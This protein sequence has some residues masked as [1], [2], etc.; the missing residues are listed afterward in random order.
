M[1]SP[2]QLFKEEIF[3]A[4]RH[5]DYKEAILDKVIEQYET[6]GPSYV[7]CKVSNEARIFRNWAR[8]VK[9]ERH[10]AIALIRLIP[11]E[12]RGVL[13]G[14]F[15]VRHKTHELIMLHFMKRFPTYSILIFFGNEACVGRDGEIFRETVERPN[16]PIVKDEFEKYW[17]T[18]YKSQYIEERRNIPYLKR[19]LPKKYWKWTP[20]LKE[21]GLI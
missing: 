6:K 7:L 9:F 4:A 19:M 5:H 10:R 15:E 3:F 11:I 21:F 20:E 1:K 16:I 2:N 12:Q 18:F 13:Y 17:L 14:E 8:Q